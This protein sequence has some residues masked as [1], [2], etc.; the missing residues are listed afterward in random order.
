M[1]NKK[2][3]TT[4][5]HTLLSAGIPSSQ[6]KGTKSSSFLPYEV[7][8]IPLACEDAGIPATNQLMFICAMLQPFP[9]PLCSKCTLKGVCLI[10][11]YIVI[12]TF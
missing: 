8:L 7:D 3:H 5:K 10:I 6:A 1:F 12:F 2:G 9:I 4:I 11:I